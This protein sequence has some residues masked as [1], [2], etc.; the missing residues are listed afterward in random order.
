MIENQLCINVLEHVIKVDLNMS[1]LINV[2]TKQLM[3]K[4][5]K[6]ILMKILGLNC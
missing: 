3:R 2:V 4:F 1:K 5:V 6:S